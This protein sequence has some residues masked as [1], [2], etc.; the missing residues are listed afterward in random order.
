[1]YKLPEGY[2]GKLV[3]FFDCTKHYD[4]DAFFCKE[5]THLVESALGTYLETTNDPS[6]RFGYRF[7]LE[8]LNKPHMLIVSY[9]D[10]KR[11]HML[12]NDCLS[13]DVSTGVFTDEIYKPSNSVK[14]I[15]RIFYPR[16]KDMT[17]TFMS[18]GKNEPAAAFGLA[19]YELDGLED[20]DNR[21]GGTEET[22]KFGLIY[23]DP[24]S[25]G[26]E[27]GAQS[28]EEW[29]DRLIKYAKHV[30]QNRFVYPIN[31][32]AGPLFDSRT[33]PSE[34]RFSVALADH[35]RFGVVSSKAIDWITPFL[36][37]C[38]AADID[39]V[40]GMTLL[41]LGNLMKNMNID[42]KSIAAGSDTYNNIRFDNKVQA[43]TN[44]WT[45]QYNVL[46]D[47]KMVK[48]GRTCYDLKD[49]EYIYGEYYCYDGVDR[50]EIIGAPLFNPIHPEVQK[51][52]VE[53]FEE[54]SEKYGHK[55]AFKG[56]SINI[57]HS[58]II[59]FSSLK[60][61]YD[62]YTVNL[63]SKETGIR[64][65]CEPT[66]PNRFR[67]R[68]E[69]LVHRNRKLW[70][71]WRCK[72]IHE[73]ISKLR[74]ALRK[75]NPTLELYLCAWVNEP[76]MLSIFRSFDASTQ[77][78]VSLSAYDLLRE[79]G[80]DLS[81]FAEDEGIHV[82]VDQN[83]HRDSSGWTQEGTLRPKEQEHVYH[84]INYLDDSWARV[85]R[86]LPGSGSLV[87]DTWDEGWGKHIHMPFN[88]HTPNI[89]KALE[90]LGV[91]AEDVVF[92]EDTCK[93]EGDDFWFESQWQISSCFPPER[94]YLEPFAHAIAEIDPL[95]LLRG[96]LY[97]DG[98]HAKEMREYAAVFTSLPAVKFE[99]VEGKEDPVV[100]RELNMNG[101]Y[102]IYAVNREPY[103]V[104]VKI[105]LRSA[106]SRNKI[107]FELAPFALE[108]YTCEAE[109]H[110]VSYEAIIPDIQWGIIKQQYEE[111]MQVFQWLKKSE[112]CVA[113]A[114]Q[115][116][117]ML[118]QAYNEN[119]PAQV[120][121]ILN[122]YVCAKAR[123][124]YEQ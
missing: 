70:I 20:I 100:V 92:S 86:K 77:Y 113:G 71:D 80:I 60:I 5:G 82:S 47:E 49:F 72:K 19:V 18:W 6:S 15:H 37:K 109:H 74:D 39:F 97:L 7:P 56:L 121:H 3:V 98:S 65:P 67:K 31:W 62:D 26:M 85:V 58:T 68:Y 40:G 119:K 88:Q 78:P 106:E 53:Y 104:T 99:T 123:A 30:G 4:R 50:G 34:Y 52:L 2:Q 108:S 59:W 55:K 1:M 117:A 8:N 95:Y 79:G 46:N 54:I 32:Y 114:E 33:Q 41:R 35:H 16:T 101:Q 96:G 11:R 118:V 63:F 90:K 83:Q 38:E 17:I 44:D 43:S 13:Y 69:Y 112:Y 124:Y 51:Q 84:D 66:D 107:Q 29:S 21:K 9:P 22:R 61:G 36:D 12:I 111:Q 81:F 116:E 42:M 57:W 87:F 122:C 23:E 91:N 10:D 103:N 89:D 115:I 28:Y 73:L 14:K 120:R 45:T 64:V 48:E 76:I 93:I 105:E 25:P 94:N 27:L 102:Y 24:H 110:A 75:C